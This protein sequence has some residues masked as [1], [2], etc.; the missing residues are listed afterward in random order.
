MLK[1]WILVLLVV[2][3]PVVWAGLPVT[4]YT[5]KNGMRVLVYEDHWHRSFRPRSGIES[6]VTTSRPVRPAFRISWNI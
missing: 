3:V 5:L 6:A 1:R 4:E 2:T